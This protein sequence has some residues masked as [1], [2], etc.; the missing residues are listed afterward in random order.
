MRPYFEKCVSCKV[1][2]YINTCRKAPARERLVKRSSSYFSAEHI[3]KKMRSGTSE[4][5]FWNNDT[6]S[7][8]KFY[9][10]SCRENWYTKN[11]LAPCS[12]HIINVQRFAIWT[13]WK[14]NIILICMRNFILVQFAR[15]SLSE[16]SNLNDAQ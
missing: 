6:S 8:M 11:T 14:S 16:S 2:L 3:P 15:D 5:L 12:A 10:A 9:F 4:R 13:H 1:T 7:I